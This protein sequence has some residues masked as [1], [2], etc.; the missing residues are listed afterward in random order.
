M[1]AF[2]LRASDWIASI[3]KIGYLPLAPGTW[4]SAVALVIWWVLPAIETFPYVLIL[5]NLFL[6]GVIVSAIVSNGN[7]KID[8]SYVVVDEWVGMWI[9]LAVVPK[10]WSLM[11]LAFLLFRFFDIVKVFPAR[12]SESLGGG[13]GIMLD[14]VIAA[15]YTVGVIEVVKL[16]K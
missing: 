11:V 8:P 16:V 5:L 4:A 7:G 13:W 2:L 10:T 3:A 6:V 12:Q 9:A 1:R 15:A 14:D